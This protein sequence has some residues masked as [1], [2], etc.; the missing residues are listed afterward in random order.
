MRAV[1]LFAGIGGF[2]EGAEQ[3]GCTVVWAANHWREAVT[4]HEANHPATAHKCQ[5]L[6]QADW[7]QVP[8]HD[9]LLASPACTGHTPA[10]GKDRPHHD[11]ARATAWAVISALECHRPDFGI[12]ENVPAFTRWQLFP[13]WC[14]ALDALGY[15][16]SPHLVDAADFAVPQNRERILIVVSRSKNPI[17]LDLPK[18]AHVPAA[19][20]VDFD[21]GSWSPIKKPGRSAATVAR[22]ED[23]RR[24]FGPRFVA[25]YYSNGSGLTGRSLD[26]PI[27]TITTVDRWAVIDGDRMRMLSVPESRDAMAFRRD[28]RLPARHKDAVKMLGNAVPPPMARGA[29]EALRRAA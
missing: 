22:I 21:A 11:P 25:P 7:T 23:G 1:D 26:R 5:D 27:G 8:A 13:A 29:I 2:T 12:V 10:R 9:L 19:S 3:A 24:K 6:H 17:R 18:L 4:L 28:Y 15:A 14:A 16:V 20:F